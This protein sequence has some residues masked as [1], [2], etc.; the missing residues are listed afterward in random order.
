MVHDLMEL[1]FPWDGKLPRFNNIPELL[2]YCIIS[3]LGFGK[4]YGVICLFYST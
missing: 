3:L 1:I 2:I 4:V